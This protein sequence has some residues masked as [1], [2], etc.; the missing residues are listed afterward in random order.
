MTAPVTATVIQ[1]GSLDYVALTNNTSSDLLVATA[2][3]GQGADSPYPTLTDALNGPAL[4]NAG[5]TKGSETGSVFGRFGHGSIT[6]IDVLIF[7]TTRYNVY[8][9]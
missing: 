2:V 8:S 1:S 5:Q 3:D 6:S 4:I 9:A 7:G